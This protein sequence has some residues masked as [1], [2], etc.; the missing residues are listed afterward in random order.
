MGN[1]GRGRLDADVARLRELATASGGR[2]GLVAMPIAGR[3]RFVL[4]LD[5][6]TTGTAEYPRE[7]QRR[8]RIEIELGI[9]YPFQ[10]P[11]VTVLTPVFHPHVFPSGIVCIGARWSASEGMD[12]FVRRIARLLAYDPL[13][14]NPGS[15]ANPAAFHW[16]EA[17]RRRHP[18]AFPTD[19]A[20]VA[21][22]VAADPVA[23]A[24]RVTRRCPNCAAALRLPA[25]RSGTVRCPRC[26]TAFEAGT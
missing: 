5:Y 11:K 20:A 12:L 18:E 22:G 17:T 4:D 13:L 6:V 26:A 10:P 3:S 14:V 7:A 19:A 9:R 16:Y 1:G 15:I 21:L 2:I 8:S 25:G 23:P 24:Q